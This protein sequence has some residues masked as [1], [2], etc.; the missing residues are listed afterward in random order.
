MTAEAASV[1]L[2]MPA[3][4]TRDWPH[5]FVVMSGFPD[6]AITRRARALGAILLAKPFTSDDLT[7]LV[8]QLTR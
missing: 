1:E 4:R 6:D 5:V 2:A 7:R 8:R 3:R